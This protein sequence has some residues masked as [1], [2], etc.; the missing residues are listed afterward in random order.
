MKC[1]DTVARHDDPRHLGEVVK[2]DGYKTATDFVALSM[3]VRWLDTGW[4][5]KCYPADV[6]IVEHAAAYVPQHFNVV[7]PST[8]VESA[9]RKLER[10]F[11]D[12]QDH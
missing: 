2:V 11:N 8:V 3:T 7:R 5:E 12:R 6:T 1:G 10:W 9:R 4:R